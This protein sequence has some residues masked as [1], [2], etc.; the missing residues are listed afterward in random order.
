MR[1]YLPCLGQFEWKEAKEEELR[2][3]EKSCQ[4]PVQTGH[5]GPYLVPWTSF[6]NIPTHSIQ[7]R[8]CH[9]DKRSQPTN[10]KSN[11]QSVF[12]HL[13]GC[14][15]TGRPWEQRSTQVGCTSDVSAS[16]GLLLPL[17]HWMLQ[18]PRRGGGMERMG[19]GRGARR[20]SPT[21]KPKES[22]LETKITTRPALNAN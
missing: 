14:L 8:S 22:L 10:P 7:L 4:A 9:N 18:K 3:V 12:I 13:L 15:A 17:T 1:A 11:Y 5:P 2:P 21:E 16:G 20:S 6:Y 19:L